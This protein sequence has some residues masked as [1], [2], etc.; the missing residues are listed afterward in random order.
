MNPMMREGKR[1]E[2]FLTPFETSSAIYLGIVDCFA[3]FLATLRVSTHN[4][5]MEVFG[6]VQKI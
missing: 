4:D 5:R 1:E 3:G 6:Q 2:I